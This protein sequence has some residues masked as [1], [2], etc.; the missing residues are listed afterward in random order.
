[1]SRDTKFKKGQSGNP[2]GRPKGSKNKYSV[3]EMARAMQVVEKRKR[4]D[5]LDALIDASWGDA[6][7]MCNVLSFM[8]PKLKAVE[9]TGA[10]LGGDMDDDLAKAIQVKLRARYEEDDDWGLI[11][12]GKGK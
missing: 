9:V 1:M 12:N 5:F 4:Q 11:R 2:N 6:T 10:I 7:A 3:A 8:M